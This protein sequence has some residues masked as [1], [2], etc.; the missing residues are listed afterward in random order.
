MATGRQ[1]YER[2]LREN[3][4]A[5]ATDDD[6][7]RAADSDSELLGADVGRYRAPLS[8]ATDRC[9]ARFVDVIERHD[10]TD[11]RVLLGPVIGKVTAHSAV[12]LIEVSARTVLTVTLTDPVSQ[13]AVRMSQRMPARRP[14][15]FVVTELRPRTRYEVSRVKRWHRGSASPR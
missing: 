10:N 7:Q 13:H 11:A 12:L 15:S 5:A 4:V 1:E 14:R 6:E 8:N 3:A 9:V 2:F